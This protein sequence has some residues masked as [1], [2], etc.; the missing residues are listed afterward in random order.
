MAVKQPFWDSADDVPRLPQSWQV[1][2]TEEAC[3]QLKP[4]QLYD[5]RTAKTTGKVPILTQSETG[6]LGFHDAE[7]GVHASEQV[8]VV[9][10]ANHTCVLRLLRHPFSCIQ[11]IFPKVGK[12]GLVDTLFYYYACQGRVGTAEYKGHHPTFRKA[13]IPIPPLPVQR[14]IASILSA[15]DDLIENCERRIRLLDEMARAL[16]REWFVFLHYPG[17]EKTPLVDSPLGRTPKGWQA[18]PL[19]AVAQV[20]ARTLDVKRAPSHIHYIDIS[21]VSPGR[22]D[23]VTKYAFADAPNRARRVVRHGDVLWSCVR[24]NRKSHVLILH[25]AE[26]T[27]ASTG[28]AVLTAEKVPASFLYVATTSDEFVG[29]LEKRATGAAYPAVTAQVF[30]DAPLLAPDS[31]V[32]T[33]FAAVVDPLAETIALLNRRIENLRK[34]RDRLLPRLLSGQ[35]SV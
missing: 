17:H 29:Y 10:F 9:T 16:Y 23:T 20:N 22:V 34:T 1:L 30:Q 8:P 27:I 33:Q 28:F 5:V 32:L 35:L 18:V 15:Y 31:S 21:S 12:P 6:Y 11:N 7:P 25:P 3:V 26:A 14:R 19:S 24:P 13:L 4:G 2:T